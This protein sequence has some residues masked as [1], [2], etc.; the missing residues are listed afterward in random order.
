MT[1]AVKYPTWQQAFREMQAIRDQHRAEAQAKAREANAELERKAGYRLQQA[2]MHFGIYID[3]APQVNLVEVDG[4]Q[5]KLL[6]SR[7]ETGKIGDRESFS[8]DLV[9]QKP[10]PGRA[11][12]DDIQAQYRSIT[13]NT[14]NLKPDFS[15]DYYLCQLADTFDDLD[16][17]VAFD[18]ARDIERKQRAEEQKIMRALKSE[19]PEEKLF[20]LFRSLIREEIAKQLEY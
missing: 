12:D 9:V 15:W 13:V 4:Y 11:E 1:D 19:T 16:E 8:F 17:A 2:L 10:I 3:P 7:Y 6:G 18:V 14:A 20:M 5:F